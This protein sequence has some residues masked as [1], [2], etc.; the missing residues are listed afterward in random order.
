MCQRPA[1]AKLLI[2]PNHTYKRKLL[3]SAGAA[4]GATQLDQRRPGVTQRSQKRI[5]QLN[6]V[7]YQTALTETGTGIL[8]SLMVEVCAKSRDHSIHFLSFSFLK[9]IL[10]LNVARTVGSDRQTVEKRDKGLGL[11]NHRVRTNSPS[12]LR[13]AS[14]SGLLSFEPQHSDNTS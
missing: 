12:P 10:H 2:K 11:G 5:K 9:D 8:C 1:A 7:P 3:G 14:L 13:P 4:E 6:T